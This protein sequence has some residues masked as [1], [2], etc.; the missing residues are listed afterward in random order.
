LKLRRLLIALIL[1]VLAAL[2]LVLPASSVT[3]AQEQE[4]TCPPPDE[5]PL[6]SLRAHLTGAEV[7]P[8][9]A[10]DPDASGRATVEVF[11][12]TVSYNLR[13]EGIGEP[14]GANEPATAAHIHFGDPGE[15]GP[16]VVTLFGLPDEQA[17]V[18]SLRSICVDVPPVVS[19]LLNADPR[20]FYV[21]VHSEDFPEGAIR[22]QLRERTPAGP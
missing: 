20:D 17:A 16:V 3:L 7:G 4:D 11:S 13:Y 1:A 15:D 19:V 12:G 21:D 9:P 18:A 5:S 2:A 8:E 6:T 14:P 10:G 22:G